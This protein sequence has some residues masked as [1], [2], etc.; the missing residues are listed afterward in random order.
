MEMCSSVMKY[1][2][3]TIFHST[4]MCYSQ[5]W[6]A[7][8]N[9]RPN[10]HSFEYQHLLNHLPSPHSTHKTLPCFTNIKENVC[11]LVYATM[12]LKMQ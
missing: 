3:A 4:I 9:D 1:I 12:F 2:A 11:S 7:L 8:L 6:S 10:N 5:H